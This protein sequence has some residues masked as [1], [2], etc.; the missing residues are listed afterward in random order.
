[1]AARNYVDVFR[2]KV[3]KLKAHLDKFF[4]A[5]G[6]SHSLLAYLV[7]LAEGTPQCAS[8][9]E[10]RSASTKNRDEGFLTKMKAGCGDL[11]LFRLLAETA[12]PVASVYAAVSGTLGAGGIKILVHNSRMPDGR[13]KGSSYR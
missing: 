4:L 13:Q 1:M 9:D 8:G 7:V 11:K 5:Y 12:F 10:N 3:L 6:A 2:T